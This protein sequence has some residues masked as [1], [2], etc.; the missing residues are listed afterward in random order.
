MGDASNIKISTGSVLGK[1]EEM[2]GLYL[3]LRA[4][5]PGLPRNL[6]IAIRSSRVPILTEHA[7]FILSAQPNCTTR[8]ITNGRY[9]AFRLV[10][11]ASYDG[12]FPFGIQF[13]A[14]VVFS[15]T[16]LLAPKRP[17][18]RCVCD[19]ARYVVPSC[20]CMKSREDVCRAYCTFL[21]LYT[22]R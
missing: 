19:L 22:T 4:G 18:V 20:S 2:L 3:T 10:V 5:K 6:H 14:N 9:H 15:G 8:L 17:F 16:L 7:G 1:V 13:R 11:R 12:F 21:R